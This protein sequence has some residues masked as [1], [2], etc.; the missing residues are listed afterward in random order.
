MKKKVS[1]DELADAVVN[2]LQKYAG[3][4]TV[5]VKEDVKT[6]AAQ[7]LSEVKQKSPVRYGDYQKGWK[8]AKVSENS[9]SVF[10]T[11]YNK[12]HYRLTHLL[13]KGHL[14]RNGGRTREF[15]HIK[16][17]EENAKRNLMKA[18]EVTVKNDS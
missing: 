14:T 3:A 2:E 6:V 4:V 8:K 11:V 7:C 18:I 16:P 15:P 12:D 13:E 5:D 17:A 9:T 10:I 1:I